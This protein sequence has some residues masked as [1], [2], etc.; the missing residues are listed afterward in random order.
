MKLT[1]IVSV[2]PAW[3]V[4]TLKS[5]LTCSGNLNVSADLLCPGALGSMLL[6]V[7]EGVL[8]QI[9]RH[10]VAVLQVAFMRLK[11]RA[12]TCRYG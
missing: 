1:A 9:V 3:L 12:P 4:D 2:P 5:T 11:P 7:S 8:L 6:R 10:P